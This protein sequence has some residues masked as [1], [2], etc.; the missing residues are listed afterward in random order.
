[1]SYRRKGNKSRKNKVPKAHNYLEE[2]VNTKDYTLDSGIKDI[3][4]LIN[5]IK[6]ITPCS[7]QNSSKGD[8][9][10]VREDTC[11]SS[12]SEDDMSELRYKTNA[13]HDSDPEVS[14]SH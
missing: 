12:S 2:V 5:K 13:Y 10:I 14:L 9:V 3:F 8:K 4:A 1:M 7:L 6:T 11:E